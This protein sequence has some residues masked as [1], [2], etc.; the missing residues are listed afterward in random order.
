[1]IMNR[2]SQSCPR[3]RHFSTGAMAHSTCICVPYRPIH[4]ST[5]EELHLLF[6]DGES[7]KPKKISS[8]LLCSVALRFD[9]S[10]FTLVLSTSANLRCKS[11]G[12]TR[13]W[14]LEP[15]IGPTSHLEAIVSGQMCRR[16]LKTMSSS[17]YMIKQPLPQEY[18]SD[19][20]LVG[21]SGTSRRRNSR[22][23]SE[24]IPEESIYKSCTA[25][26]RWIHPALCRLV[27]VLVFWV[28][29]HE[30]VLKCR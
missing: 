25:D 11:M 27:H 26:P 16:R 10:M 2:L 18:G 21:S 14:S 24:E 22:C 28:V 15:F 20:S 29:L 19:L 13:N 3:E 1:M 8:P 9:H 12:T 17:A 6:A 5:V 4:V 23:Q 30:L 7:R